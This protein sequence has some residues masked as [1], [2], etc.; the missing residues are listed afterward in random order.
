[1]VSLVR[2]LLRINPFNGGVSI[3]KNCFDG[4]R[5]YK[6]NRCGLLFRHECF[7]REILINGTKCR[8]VYLIRTLGDFYIQ[9]GCVLY[10]VVSFACLFVIN[11]LDAFFVLLS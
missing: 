8:L 6:S 11:F 5:F 7:A 10:G 2:Y 4:S 1:M 3:E 9:L